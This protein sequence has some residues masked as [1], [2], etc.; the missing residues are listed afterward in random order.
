MITEDGLEGIAFN[1]REYVK[2]ACER[3]TSITRVKPL[4]G[5]APPFC[6]EGSLT[7]AEDEVKGELADEACSVL[8][9]DLWAARLAWPDLTKAITALASKVSKWTR[10][11]DRMLHRLRCY[12]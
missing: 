3:Y 1:M 4:K 2:A 6:P 12:M 10:N 5:A 8:V 7:V 9:K 11:H